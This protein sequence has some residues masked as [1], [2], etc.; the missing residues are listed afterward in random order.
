MIASVLRLV[1]FIPSAFILYPSH[2]ISLRPNSHLCRLIAKF[3]SFNLFSVLSI[4]T[5]CFSIVPFVMIIMS[6]RN[7]FVEFNPSSFV[8]IIF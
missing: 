6:S 7:A 4:S 2:V 3:S 5:S 1:G 8:S